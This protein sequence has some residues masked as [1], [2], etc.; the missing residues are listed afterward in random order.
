MNLIMHH[1]NFRQRP[2]KSESFENIDVYT[3]ETS[4]HNGTE[5]LIDQGSNCGNQHRISVESQWEL[6]LSK[7]KIQEE[8]VLSSHKSQPVVSSSF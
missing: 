3:Q 7:V 2:I 6:L 8:S 1:R 5:D 4:V